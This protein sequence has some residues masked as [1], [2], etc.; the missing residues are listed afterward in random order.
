M[1]NKYIYLTLCTFL[2]SVF[3]SSCTKLLEVDAPIDS[4]TTEELFSTNDQAE[5]AISAIYSKM[6]NG[7]Q[8]TTIQTVADRGFAAGL[9]TILGGLSSDELTAPAN[10]M[11]TYYLASQNKLSVSNNS[12]TDNIWTSAYKIIFD[13]NAVIEGLQ[14]S[15]SLLLTDSARKQLKGEALALR[16]FCYFYLVNFFGDVPLVLTADFNKTLGLPRWPVSKIYDQ[17]KEDLLLAKSMLRDDFAASNNERVRVNKWFAEALLSRIYL[18][19][20]EYQEAIN[21]ATAVINQTAL[22][23]IETDLSQTFNRNSIEAIFQLKQTAEAPVLAN[24]TPEGYR[25]Y[26]VPVG[27]AVYFP[28]LEISSQ[29]ANSL[30]LNDKRKT[31]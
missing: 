23:S 3:F 16:S 24:A 22:F 13:A 8:I 26:N 11:G 12:S 10:L 4:I 9:S 27:V 31:L 17:I 7:D 19:N 5:W 20:G 25:M 29:L 1:P 6:I 2:L 21:A 15:K 18:Y 30:E 14:D 28:G